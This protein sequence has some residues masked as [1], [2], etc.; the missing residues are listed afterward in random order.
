VLSFVYLA[1]GRIAELL[2]LLGRSR[3]RKELEILVLRH[4]L[5]VLRRQGPRVPY[6]A[7]DRALL[8]A[9][10]RILPRAR[11]P[12]T[13]GVRPATVLRW[14]RQMVRR[15]W[16]FDSRHP[17]RPGLD[18]DLVALIVRL[19]RENRRWGHRRIVGELA[20]LGISVSETS[21]RNIL[22]A[23][24]LEP[25]P[26]RSG[27]SWRAFIHQQARTMIACDFFTVETVSLRRICVLFFIEIQ[28]RRVHLAGCTSKPDGAWVTQQAR[29]LV[30][31]LE[32]RHDPFRFLLHDRTPSSQ[33]PSMRS[34][35]RSASV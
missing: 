19:A 28:T 30:M 5:K 2:V 15:R 7:Q 33:R 32:D 8:A 31:E 21:V 3:E 27:H 24:G 4:E 1:L 16:S 23:H 12:T 9:L 18:R 6:Q 34:S 13:F 17:G 10:S 22:K 11:W 35:G 20:K 14:H 26:R 25:A 29:N